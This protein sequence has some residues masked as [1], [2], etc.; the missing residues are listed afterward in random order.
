[1]LCA[2]PVD[3]LSSGLHTQKILRTRGSWV[4]ILPGAP[5][6]ND[7]AAKTKSSFLLWDPCGTSY[8]PVRADLTEFKHFA[9]ETKSSFLVVG[10]CGICF[11]TA[12]FAVGDA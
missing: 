1:M 6:F 5:F 4:R 7:L 10:A 11:C 8:P 12:A 9:A 3:W 2:L